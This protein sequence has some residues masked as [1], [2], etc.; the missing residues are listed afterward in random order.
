MQLLDSL[1]E[2][3]KGALH[4]TTYNTAE[5]IFR[6]LSNRFGN[7]TAI[8]IEIV[9][10]LQR[11]PAIKN[12]QPRKIVELIQ[13]VE[14]ALQ[15]LIDLGDTGAIENPLVTKSIETKLPD[16]LKK[17]WLVYAA[18]KKNAVTPENRF[19]SLLMFLRAQESIYEQLEHLR[20]EEPNRRDS[21]PEAR[22][23]RTKL[24]KTLGDEGGCVVCGDDKHTKKLYF[25][26]RFKTLNLSARKA[27]VRELGA[28]RRCLEVH[29]HQSGCKPDFLC[30]NQGCRNGAAPDHHYFLCPNTEVR[31]GAVTQRKTQL[32]PVS[33]KDQKKNT[34]EQEEFLRKLPPELAKECRDVFS[35]VA[36][37]VL[38]SRGNTPGL[39]AAMVCRSSLCL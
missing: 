18:D 35:N 2:K 34:E 26:K 4:L 7:R 32:S 33:G 11:M 14:K 37:K 20:E 27:A 19:D 13:A 36:T 8:A 30:K 25:C 24:T 1:D 28:C 39:L 17:E 5:D 16:T 29:N 22:H 12:N 38:N 21:R 3:I 23:A 31:K 9:E 10:E 15:D 6:V